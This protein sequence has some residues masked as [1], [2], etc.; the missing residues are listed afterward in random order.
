M[1]AQRNRRCS[2]NATSVGRRTKQRRGCAATR[3]L[4][5]KS[6]AYKVSAARSRAYKVSPSCACLVLRSE[7]VSCDSETWQCNPKTGVRLLPRSN[8]EDGLRCRCRWDTP[9]CHRGNASGRCPVSPKKMQESRSMMHLPSSLVSTSDL[10]WLFEFCKI[11][12][13]FFSVQ[14][15]TVMLGSIPVCESQSVIGCLLQ[16]TCM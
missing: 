9:G 1:R 12:E 7:P 10:L 5:T 14:S 13:T 3:S 16:I 8:P 11:Y 15:N 4:R 6:G 2:T